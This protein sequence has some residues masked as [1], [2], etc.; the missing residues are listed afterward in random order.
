MTMIGKNGK[1]SHMINFSTKTIIFFDSSSNIENLKSY[2][3]TYVITFDYES[4]KTLQKNNIQ[5]QTSDDFL[6]V[7]DLQT[8]QKKSYHFSR[9]YNE[10]TI[11]QFLEYDGINL[12]ELFNVEFHYS[13]IP[14]LKKFVEINNIVKKFP[15]SKFIVTSDL[16]EITETFSN[17]VEKLDMVTESVHKFLYDSI[18]HSFQIGRHSFT[19]NISKKNYKKIKDLSYNILKTFF[20][21]TKSQSNT[22]SIL[23]VEFDTVKHR[24]FFAS[25]HSKSIITFCRRRPVIWN[26][27][28]LSIIKNSNCVVPEIEIHD[29]ITKNAIES[30]KSETKLKICSMWENQNFFKSFFTLNEISFWECMRSFFIKLCEKRTLEAIDEIIITKKLFEKYKIRSVLVW[31]ENGFNEQI[32]LNLARKLS[33]STV[34]IQHGGV[35]HDAPVAYE[36]NVFAGIIPIKSDKFI[37][38]GNAYKEHALSCGISSKKIEALGSPVYDEIFEKK[39][40]FKIEKNFILLTP[41]SP[42]QSFVNDLTVKTQENNEF[43]IREIC[44]II[45]KFNKK[46]VV[47]MKSWQEELNISN[48]VKEIIPDAIIVEQGDIFSYIKNCEVLI[49][50]DISSTILEAQILE[51]PVISV[52][53][54]NWDLG[55]PSVFASNSCVDT[56]IENF[57]YY[58]KKILE[59]IDFRNQF[60]K[61]GND[62]VDYSLINKGTASEKILEFL[63]II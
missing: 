38:W 7:V 23:L 20:G 50:I 6:D 55:I 33:I 26:L 47:K 48:I 59:D 13:L 36:Y 4:H 57:E 19:I 35:G 18:R 52:S 60:I 42:A 39:P 3:N 41:T 27:Q 44:K 8:I 37:T 24:K 28:S 53:V 2:P 43:A 32:V 40:S 49:V 21:I 22:E 5:H 45:S 56:N 9:W 12:G 51:K 15:E 61:N 17:Q 30:I 1:K 11:S 31:S 46:L 34:L 16:F 29:E 14:F 25:D 63:K 62:Y 54:K 58:L 10:S